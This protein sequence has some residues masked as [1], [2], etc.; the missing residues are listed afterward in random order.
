MLY[1]HKG[2]LDWDPKADIQ[3]KQVICKL[4]HVEE[5]QENTKIVKHKKRDFNNLQAL[6]KLSNGNC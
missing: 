6:G 2:Y 4:V 1:L 5:F 3:R